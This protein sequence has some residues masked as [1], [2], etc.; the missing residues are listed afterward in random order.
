MTDGLTLYFASTGHNSPGGY[1]LFVTRYNLNTD[2][3]L[4]PSQMN[5]PF[6]SPFNDFM[7]VIDEEK[8][9]GWFASDRFQSPD[10][11]IVYTFIPNPQVQL[12]D[13]NDE[14]YLARR[15][16]ITSIRDSWRDGQD[17]TAIIQRARQRVA[18][19]QESQGDFEF[20][21]NDNITYRTLSDFRNAQAHTQFSQAL[22]L[23][24]QLN[25]LSGQLSELRNQFPSNQS[26]RHTI[27]DLE[28]QTESLH[29]QVESLKVE[30]RNAE[31]RNGF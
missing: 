18:A 12:L 5:P 10:S 7:L 25:T 30:A 3:Y 13:V 2:S 26:L 24:S 9:A 17:Y 6:N 29:R 22:M 11:V 15:A 19:Q 16:M 27:L 8:G 4:N 1:D 23:E 20:I 21:I 31:I 14:E 28:R